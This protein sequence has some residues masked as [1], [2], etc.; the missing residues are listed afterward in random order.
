MD[1]ALEVAVSK[2]YD[3]VLD[4]SEWKEALLRLGN[5]VQGYGGQFL[6]WDDESR[7]APFSV[8]VGNAQ[9]AN[10]LYVSHYGAIDPRLKFALA[11]VGNRWVLPAGQWV[12]CHEICDDREVSRSEF[13]QDFLIP[14]GTRYMTGSRLF[15]DGAMH[16]MICFGKHV[17]DQPFSDESRAKLASITSHLILAGRLHMRLARLREIG[18]VH[19]SLVDMLDY[20]LI[21][22]DEQGRVEF[23]NRHASE[24][25]ASWRNLPDRPMLQRGG[26]LSCGDPGLHQRLRAALRACTSAMPVADSFAISAAGSPWCCVVTPLRPESGLNRASG[27]PRA[28]ILLFELEP[29]TRLPEHLL[30]RLF[31][32]TPAEARVALAISNGKSVKRLAAESHVGVA[33]VRTQLHQVFVKSGLRRQAELSAL[34]HRLGNMRLPAVE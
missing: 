4:P 13:Y 8:M 15:D 32:L 12:L 18:Q 30:R 33:T 7:V 14:T 19:S 31:G 29:R 17:G 1:P 16:S 23:A 34:V 9:E 20:G 25:L 26:S 28:L 24:T 2:V 5:C 6:V 3:A 11:R 10:D 22:A 21:V 27:M